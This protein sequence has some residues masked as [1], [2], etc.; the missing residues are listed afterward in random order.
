MPCLRCL[1]VE[2]QTRHSVAFLPLAGPEK[3]WEETSATEPYEENKHKVHN[4]VGKCQR[5]N[6]LL[7]L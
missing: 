1:F 3:A 2:A 4:L 6:H 7:V 5:N